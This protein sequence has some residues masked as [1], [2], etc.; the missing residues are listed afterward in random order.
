MTL[1]AQKEACEANYSKAR[2]ALQTLERLLAEE[3]RS[4]NKK[5]TSL[6]PLP[7]RI[8]KG[9]VLADL[10]PTP[11]HRTFSD[12]DLYTGPHTGALALLLEEHGITCL[13]HNP[14]HITFC[15]HGVTIEAHQYLFFFDKDRS[16]YDTCTPLSMP[17]AWQ[18]LFLA[19]H[20][21]Y[22]SLFFDYPVSLRTCLD[23]TLLLRSMDSKE[24]ACL[25]EEK[26]GSTSA[27]FADALTAYCHLLF[28]EARLERY[29]EGQDDAQDATQGK[30][31]THHTLAEASAIPF[32]A[33]FCQ[34]RPRDGHA[35]VRVWHRSY[36]Y[37]V[38][39]KY[40]KKL[41]G[42][43]MFSAFYFNNLWVALKQHAKHIKQ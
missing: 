27:Y 21:C 29:F 43:S 37:I 3:E 2:E 41:F 10:Y 18:A 11:Q 19:A 8:V 38:Y 9:F 39:N 17:P 23:W 31:T 40:Y 15:F 33:M 34:C 30:R 28:P 4:Q 36:K 35:F 42:K 24:I 26:K 13:R 25:F 22:D 5:S 32:K 16:I 12:I 20:A 14:R 1:V 7:L 6:P